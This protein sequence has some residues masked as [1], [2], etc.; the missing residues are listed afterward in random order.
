MDRE[1]ARDLFINMVETDI[2]ILAPGENYK[3]I[4][5][6]EFER[7]TKTFYNFFDNLS[8]TQMDGFIY[9]IIKDLPLPRQMLII[10]ILKGS[11][12]MAY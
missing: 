5:S 4:G 2:G 8:E 10:D 3:E 9:K 12:N 11:G 1:Q 7:R 6:E